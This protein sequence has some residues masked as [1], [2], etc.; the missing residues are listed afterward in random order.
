MFFVGYTILQPNIKKTCK[1]YNAKMNKYQPQS[2]NQKN[3]VLDIN[4]STLLFIFFKK[5]TQSTRLERKKQRGTSQMSQ[6]VRF[7]PFTLH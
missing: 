1:I 6:E 4:F 7:P 5:R 3:F 2:L